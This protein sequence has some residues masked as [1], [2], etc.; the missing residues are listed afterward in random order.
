MGSKKMENKNKKEK[1]GRE[2]EGIENKNRVTQ[3][4]EKKINK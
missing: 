4:N 2:R 1:I 3:Q